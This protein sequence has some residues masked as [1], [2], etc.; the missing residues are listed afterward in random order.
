MTKTHDFIVRTTI[1]INSRIKLSMKFVVEGIYA[2]MLI[3][4]SRDLTQI[5]FVFANKFLKKITFRI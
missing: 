2:C 1:H 5:Y 3:R 4:V